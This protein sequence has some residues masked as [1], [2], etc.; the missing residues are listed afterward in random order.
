MKTIMINIILY[1]PEI[2]NNTG[3][4]MRTCSS[5]GAKLHLIGPLGF[6]LDD[7]HIKRSGMDYINTIDYK[8]YESYY[9]FLKLNPNKK[10]HYVTRY[11]SKPHSE[12]DF[13]DITEDYYIMF[14]KESSGIPLE[15]LADHL[16]DCI[17]IP[18]KPHARSLN[19]SNCVAI[20]VYEILRQQDYFGLATNET[21]KGEDYLLK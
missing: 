1:Q 10:I 15:I 3:N 4:I 11:G 17:R 6:S 5:S 2:H 16:D 13:Q 7:E 20:V 12:F 9:E 19:L 18:M 8:Y 14:G 21:I